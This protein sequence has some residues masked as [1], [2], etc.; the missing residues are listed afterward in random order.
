V[1]DNIK[2]Y[3]KALSFYGKAP[4]IKEKTLPPN[5]PDLATFYGNIGGV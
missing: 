5:H 1:Y 4:K 3:S 2:E